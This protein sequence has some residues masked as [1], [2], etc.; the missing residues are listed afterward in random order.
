M[1]GRAS[2]PTTVF[3]G[4]TVAACSLLAPGSSATARPDRAI[5]IVVSPSVQTV[6]TE[7]VA[8]AGSTPHR[9]RPRVVFG[10]AKFTITVYDTGPVA[11]T[12]IA[13]T[14]ARTPR[15][16]R[17]IGTLAAGASIT[18]SCYAANV[19]RDYAN[20]VVVSGERTLRPRDLTNTQAGQRSTFSARDSVTVKVKPKV[21]Q[22]TGHAEFT[23]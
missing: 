7:V 17:A 21:I 13:I 20:V 18:Y 2:W 9:G 10:T 14:D 19:V 15:C 3:L 6:V 1:R 11:L 4:V 8:A 16:H 12:H 23:G 5:S 22:H